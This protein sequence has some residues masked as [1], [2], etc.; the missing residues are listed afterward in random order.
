MSDTKVY[1][2]FYDKFLRQY[3]V[4]HKHDYSGMWIQVSTF[5]KTEHHAKRWIARQPKPYKEVL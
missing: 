3:F 1:Q 2:V 5:Y 4:A